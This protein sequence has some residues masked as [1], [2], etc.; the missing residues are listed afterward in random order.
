MS[1][2]MAGDGIVILVADDDSMFC[3]IIKDMISKLGYKVMF[4]YDG[5]T[6]LSLAREYQPKAILLDLVLPGTDGIDVLKVLKADFDTRHIPV[7]VISFN[8]V[9]SDIKKMGALKYIYDDAGQLLEVINPDNTSKKYSY[10]KLGNILEETDERGG[11]TKLRYDKNGNLIAST[12]PMSN[13]TR[14]AYD[15]NNLLTSI[16]YA[17]KSTKQFTYTA[18]GDISSIKDENGKLTRCF[19]DALG[20]II[21]ITDPEK[22]VTEFFY[23]E[24][25][26]IEKV[27]IDG[28]IVN[29]SW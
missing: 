17:D 19:Y 22:H 20:R 28:H 25:D 12:D 3:S 9:N 15:K 24:T 14:Y 29:K 10:D 26:N 7:K 8:D 18:K 4:A 21:R 16:T 27:T 23:D 1:E 6:A 5:S 11:K 13:T 2:E